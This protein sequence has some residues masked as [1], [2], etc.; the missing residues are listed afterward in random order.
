MTWGMNWSPPKESYEINGHGAGFEKHGYLNFLES[1]SNS[2]DLKWIGPT[3]PLYPV[4]FHETGWKSFNRKISW[5]QLMRT[6]AASPHKLKLPECGPH[7]VLVA[8]SLVFQTPN[9]LTR[10]LLTQTLAAKPLTLRQPGPPRGRW[11][12][13]PHCRSKGFAMS[14]GRG[15]QK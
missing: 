8:T 9:Q 11:W 12:R 2:F 1:S 10:F 7:S 15:R 5:I 14:R 3:S 6:Y 13:C 4:I